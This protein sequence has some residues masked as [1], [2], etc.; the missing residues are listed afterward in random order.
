M[1][2]VGRRLVAG[3]RPSALAR[4]QT[5]LICGQI[6]SL[7]AAEIDVKVIETRGDRDLTSP[8]PEIGGKGLFT[9]EFEAALLGGTIDFAVH[10]LKDLPVDESVGLATVVA[11]PRLDPRD[12]LIS[13]VGLGLLELPARARIG[14]SSLRRAGQI[15]ALRP[16][17]TV[18]A[19]RG[20]VETRV[21]KV[22]DGAFDAI[23]IAAAGLLRLD[24]SDIVTEYID[25]TMILPAPGQG[26]LALQCRASDDSMRELF[27]RI[28][29]GPATAC[30]MAERT[31]LRS[32]G[33]GCSTPVGA[34]ATTQD[35]TDQINLC[36]RVIDPAG[37]VAVDVTGSGNDPVE[38]GHRLAAEA[39]EKGAG[40]ILERG[41]YA[42]A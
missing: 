28:S 3:T 26:A 23:V 25:V 20:N 17:V 8:L 5:G 7:G 15:R 2:G 30:T 9:Q 41:A 27:G 4:A 40:D 21:R 39:L 19:I 11:E 6:G 10:S 1:G 12:V 42:P 35:G 29:G 34:L 22:K 32:L 24:R 31:F 14:T 16:D 18:L 13:D 33:A 38:L 36:A 37:D